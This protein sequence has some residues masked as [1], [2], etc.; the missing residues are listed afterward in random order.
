MATKPAAKKVIHGKK[1][2]IG[3][4]G[5]WCMEV[6]SVVPSALAFW[7]GAPAT[8]VTCPA[9]LGVQRKRRAESGAMERRKR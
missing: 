9:C 7:T 4:E 8:A 1:A 6:G 3:W 5:P 2:T